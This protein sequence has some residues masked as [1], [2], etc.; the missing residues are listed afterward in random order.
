M[1]VGLVFILLSISILALTGCTSDQLSETTIVAPV[2]TES[3]Q[4]IPTA[5]FAMTETSTSSNSYTWENGVK[6]IL[7][8]QCSECHSTTPTAGFSI[9]SYTRVMQGSNI[10]KIIIPGN[11]EE[12]HIFIKLKYAG[13]HPGYLSKEQTAIVWDWV[14]NGA[15]E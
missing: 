12:S 13:N 9:E 7:Q 2:A 3:E 1:K 4:V 6:E 14:K 10:G 11:P 15:L 8:Q 5:T